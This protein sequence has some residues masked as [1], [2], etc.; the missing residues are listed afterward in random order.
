MP[1]QNKAIEAAH[2][3]DRLERL[4][5]GATSARDLNPAQW[6]ALRF[7]SR[8][9]RFSR[10]PAALASYLGSTR[11]TVSQTLIAL[12]EKGYVSRIASTKDRRSLDLVL[13]ESGRAKLDDDPLL[14]FAGDI[15]SAT[16]SRLDDFTETLDEIL[17]TIVGR[18]GGKPFGVCHRCRHFRR[19]RGADQHHCRLLD[20][21]LSDEDSRNVCVEQEVA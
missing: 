18:V 5:R 10:T 2:L 15:V 3:L 8:A 6:D 19:G 7:L 11:G 4:S 12:E 13:T 14:T 9:N 16:N 21:P 17:R 20:E 1:A